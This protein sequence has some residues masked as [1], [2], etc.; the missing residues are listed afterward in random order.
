MERW[1]D[2][3]NGHRI[4][5]GAVVV[6]ARPHHPGLTYKVSSLPRITWSERHHMTTLAF[7]RFALSLNGC[8]RR[9]TRQG[10]RAQETGRV[11]LQAKTADRRYQ[12][13]HACA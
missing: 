9:R 11:L 8:A 1:D 7:R 13:R 12:T 2:A 3:L 10:L 5:P 6:V 4:M